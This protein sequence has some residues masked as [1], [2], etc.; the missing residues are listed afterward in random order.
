M[1]IRFKFW[2]QNFVKIVLGFAGSQKGENQ[3]QPEIVIQFIRFVKN[4]KNFIYFIYFLV[5]YNLPLYLSFN[6]L[7]LQNRLSN[8]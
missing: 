7:H 2:N 1:I 6:K 8:R 4:K 3:D 5:L